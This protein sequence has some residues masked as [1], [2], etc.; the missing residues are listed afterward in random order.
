[1]I[2][3]ASLSYLGIGIQPPG[4]QFGFDDQPIHADLADVAASDRHARHRVG[5]SDAGDQLSG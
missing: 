5:H 1:M 2:L 4:A 3:E